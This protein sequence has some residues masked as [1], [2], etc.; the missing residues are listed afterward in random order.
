MSAEE[1]LGKKSP[2]ANIVF[3]RCQFINL[4]LKKKKYK[5]QIT[6]TE[7]KNSLF[8]STKTKGTWLKSMSNFINSNHFTDVTKAAILMVMCWASS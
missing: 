2:K 4:S 7:E 1:S 5:N 3:A 6:I 8:F